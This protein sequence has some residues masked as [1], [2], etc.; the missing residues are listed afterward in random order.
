M[1]LL[2]TCLLCVLA[3]P[4][5]AQIY[6]YTDDHGNTVFTDQPPEGLKSEPVTLTP[7]NTV[8]AQTP[9]VAD[10]HS[11]PANQSAAYEVLRI[12]D[13]PSDE[14]L[15]ANNGTFSVGVEIKPRLQTGHKLRLILDGKPYGQAVNVPR[16]QLNNID[17]GEH[18]L[19][20]EVVNGE[21]SV[22]LSATQT[23]TVQRVHTNNPAARPPKPQ[24]RPAP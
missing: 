14:A 8:E 13:I 2:I 24:P 3:L 10:P 18:S 15:R 16:L 23:F 21:Q 11:E 1:R 19:A 12:T 6:K 7:T 5:T 17:R 22:Q 4:A 20:V 9:T